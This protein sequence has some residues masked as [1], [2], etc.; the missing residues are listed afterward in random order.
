M[1]KRKGV[2]CKECHSFLHKTH[3]VKT[4]LH[5][6]PITFKTWYDEKVTFYGTYNCG[7]RKNCKYCKKKK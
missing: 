7:G 6:I 3:P 4:I 2:N 5:R 1:V